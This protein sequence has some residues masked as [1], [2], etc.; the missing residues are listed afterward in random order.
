MRVYARARNA[1]GSKSW[2]VIT[3]D[4]SGDNSNVY[5][6][7]LCQALLLNLNESPFFANVGLPAEQSVQQQIAPDYYVSRI[8]QYYAPYFASLVITKVNSNPPTY[9]ISVITLQGAQLNFSLPVTASP[10]NQIPQ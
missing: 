5:L 2:V 10:P 3:T 4:S 7:A 6:V 1:D 9:N 8:Q